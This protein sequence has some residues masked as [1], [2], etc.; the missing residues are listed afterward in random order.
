MAPKDKIILMVEAPEELNH[1]LNKFEKLLKKEVGAKNIEYKH[2]EKFTAEL[3][4]K[5]ENWEIWIGL[6][7]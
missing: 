1:I 2:S 3:K 4:T 7:I 6:R 5:L